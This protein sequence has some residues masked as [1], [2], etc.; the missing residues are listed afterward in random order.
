MESFFEAFGIAHL[1]AVVDLGA[2]GGEAE[3]GF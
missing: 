3:L 2:G 1:G